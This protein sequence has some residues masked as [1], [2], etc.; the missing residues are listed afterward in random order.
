MAGFGITDN[1]WG[2]YVYGKRSFGIRRWSDYPG[3]GL[4][5]DK[6]QFAAGAVV[7]GK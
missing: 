6:G 2:P 7:Y 5:K 3:T 4:Y 1:A